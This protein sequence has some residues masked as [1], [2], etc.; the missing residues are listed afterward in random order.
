MA[1]ARHV[2][3]QPLLRLPQAPPQRLAIPRHEPRPEV[4]GDGV[5]L[6]RVALVV[7]VVRVGRARD[8][9]RRH[10]ERDDEPQQGGVQ[11]AVAEVDGRAHA[12]AAAIGEVV[13]RG[14]DGTLGSLASSCCRRLGVVEPALGAELVGVGTVDGFVWG[15]PPS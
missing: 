11:H 8:P 14:H 1:F 13:R 3:S 4:G 15:E 10:A 9:R 7:D 12:G 2:P 5:G 6:G